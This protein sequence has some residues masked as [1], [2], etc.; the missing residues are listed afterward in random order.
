MGRSDLTQGNGPQP[1]PALGAGPRRGRC[2]DGQ[3]HVALP[4]APQARDGAKPPGVFAMYDESRALQ[5]VGYRCGAPP[6][7]GS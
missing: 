5:Y 6:G 7:L 4:L 1:I 2:S 3:S